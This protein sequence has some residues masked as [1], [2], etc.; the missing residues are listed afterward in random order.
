MDKDIDLCICSRLMSTKYAV[1]A[2]ISPRLYVGLLP[3][4]L[5]SLCFKIYA[6][7][8]AHRI[9]LCGVIKVSI[10]P[11]FTYMFE[12]ALFAMQSSTYFLFL[13]FCHLFIVWS[14]GNTGFYR[15]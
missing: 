12:H 3:Y 10:C 1:F 5:K 4:F 14:I 6:C 2:Q 13:L 7:T 15:K 9:D 8:Q 11:C